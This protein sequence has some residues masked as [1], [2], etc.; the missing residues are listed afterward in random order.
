MYILH[1]VDALGIAT[2]GHCYSSPAVAFVFFM[3]YPEYS[4]SSPQIHCFR[5]SAKN[6]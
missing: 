6:P 5:T 2:L 3:S 1:K 4:I